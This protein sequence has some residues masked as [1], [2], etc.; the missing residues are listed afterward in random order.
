M[1]FIK[2]LKTKQN[3]RLK[4]RMMK[5]FLLLTTTL[6]LLITAVLIWIPVTP[7]GFVAV[8][9]QGASLK[10]VAKN[11]A[12]N[13]LA[14]AWVLEASGRINQLL[15][16]AS[17]KKT[18]RPGRY[19]IEKPQT[20]LGFWRTLNQQVPEMIE[21]K[22]LEGWNFKQI[23][24]AIDSNPELRH[25]TVALDNATLMQRLGEIT[26]HPEGRFFPDTYQLAI[27]SSDLVVY[28]AAF[29]RMRKMAQAA[30]KTKPQDS[31]INSVDELIN[32]AAI[33]EKETGAVADRGLVSSVF[34]N[35]LKLGMRLQTDPTVIYGMG[36]AYQGKIHKADLLQDTPYNTYTRGGLPPTPIA[37]PSEASLKA[38]ANP[39][40]TQYLYF[41]AKT[42]GGGAGLS[43]FSTTLEQHN[44]AVAAYL[45]SQSLRQ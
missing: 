28:K 16:S 35:R 5:R 33:V 8:V 4:Y 13:T 23:R 1:R 25:D 45:A 36:D 26:L 6:V 39:P 21:I 29:E 7:S 12:K 31:V 27:G 40:A 30:W 9:P 10:L 18:L 11:V 20:A 14:P 34:H 41:V 24:S 15:S 17:N 44:Q 38:A 42:K 43:Q 22:L 37:A 3:R 32:L 2:I 19:T